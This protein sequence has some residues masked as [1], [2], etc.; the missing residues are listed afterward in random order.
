MAA[1]KTGTEK[2]EGKEVRVRKTWMT[3]GKAAL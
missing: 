2:E 3:H 1:A